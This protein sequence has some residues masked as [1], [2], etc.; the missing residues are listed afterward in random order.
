MTSAPTQEPLIDALRQAINIDRRFFITAATDPVFESVKGAVDQLLREVNN[1]ARR[2]AGIALKEAH[3]A[4]R[5]AE[6]WVGS[7]QA[8]SRRLIQAERHFTTGSYGDYLDARALASMARTEARDAVTKR[9]SELIESISA[10]RANVNDLQQELQE[11]KYT[12]YHAPA[13]LKEALRRAREADSHLTTAGPKGNVHADYVLAESNLRTSVTE[14][15]HL[16]DDLHAADAVAES[17]QMRETLALDKRA[18]LN[19]LHVAMALLLLSV[20]IPIPGLVALTSQTTFGAIVF[21][22]LPAIPLALADSV[23]N[24]GKREPATEMSLGYLWLI[25]VSSFAIIVSLYW[26]LACYLPSLRKINDSYELQV[27][28]TYRRP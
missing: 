19:R 5:E 1:L 2:D 15:A 18:D 26:L 4:E 8:A 13:A 25:P 21:I 20:L 28:S 3:A 23:W 12:R 7:D 11:H 17:A 27:E 9:K 24:L 14:L 10:L 22:L 16:L 6:A